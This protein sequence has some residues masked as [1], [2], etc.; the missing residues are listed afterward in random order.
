MSYLNTATDCLPAAARRENEGFAEC[1][2]DTVSGLRNLNMLVDDVFQDRTALSN[3]SSEW[4]QMTFHVPPTVECTHYDGVEEN[5]AK[6]YIYRHANVNPE[7]WP[8]LLATT[9]REKSKLNAI[10]QDIATMMYT[11]ERPRGGRVLGICKG[12]SPPVRQVENEAR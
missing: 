6:W 4:T 10:L 3:K 7:S 11:R 12:L 8:S 1:W 9:N 5:D 2:K